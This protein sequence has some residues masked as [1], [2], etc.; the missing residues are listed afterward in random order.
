MNK[1]ITSN[2]NCKKSNTN[3]KQIQSELFDNSITGGG[4]RLLTIQELSSILNIKVK[5]LYKHVTDGT[6]P[7]VRIGKQ[8]RFS[9]KQ[10]ER[11]LSLGGTR[12]GN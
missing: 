12:D 3:I 5:T 8:L 7:C 6:I 4:E 2:T 11:E 1:K 10:V 9:L